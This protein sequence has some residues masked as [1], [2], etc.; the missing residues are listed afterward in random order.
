MAATYTDYQPPS[1]E[2]E[3]EPN[4]LDTSMTLIEHL[5]E[6]RRR[7]FLCL[8]AVAVGSVAAF[9]M[10]DQILSFLRLPL[11]GIYGQLV[12]TGLGESVTVI[13]K[14][15][16]GVGIG[17][18]APVWLYQVWGFLA[19]AMTRQEKRYALPF[20]LI[21]VVL[22]VIGLAVGFVTLHFPVA[23]LIGFGNDSGFH[24]LLSAESY[25]SFVLFFM[26]AFGA[27]FEL[28]LVLTFLA[29]IGILSS[30]RLAKN[31]AYA[32]VGLWV[33]AT[34]ITP[35]ADPYSPIILGVSLTLLYFLSELLIRVIGK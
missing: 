27:T 5:A 22:F 6:L 24:E 10:R 35:G 11:A 30:Q 28:P 23:F 34:V 29:V 1:V 7:L 31:R 21:G 17:V 18:A 15:C 12:V 3:I 32:L 14:I 16:L 2:H 33:L 9:V 19:P 4:T 13:L 25:F 20:T 8:I 26:L